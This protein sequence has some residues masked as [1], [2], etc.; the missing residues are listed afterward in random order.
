MSNLRSIDVAY[1]VQ[2]TPGAYSPRIAQGRQA[3]Q[4]LTWIYINTHLKELEREG[5]ATSRLHP[6]RAGRPDTSC[7]TGIWA[8]MDTLL[9]RLLAVGIPERAA[10]Q[11]KSYS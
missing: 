7:V 10:S 8:A 3:M 6:L 2:L 5:E 1:H 9:R 4:D 11:G